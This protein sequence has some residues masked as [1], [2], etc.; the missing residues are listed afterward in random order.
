MMRT[1]ISILALSAAAPAM[2]AEPRYLDVWASSPRACKANPRKTEDA[3]FRITSR[4][5]AGYEWSCSIKNTSRAGEGGWRVNLACA[6]E[7]DETRSTVRWQVVGDKLVETRSG[8]TTV[9]VRCAST[10]YRSPN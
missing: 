5:M 6:S 8:K 4:D 2:A 9:S 7:G 1:L 3:A 10:D